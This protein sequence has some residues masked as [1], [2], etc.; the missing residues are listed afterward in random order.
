MENMTL[1][2]LI[3][4]VIDLV[5]VRFLFENSFQLPEARKKNMTLNGPIDGITDFG[6]ALAYKHCSLAFCSFLLQID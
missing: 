4:F 3:A 1:C 2:G 6:I 5:G